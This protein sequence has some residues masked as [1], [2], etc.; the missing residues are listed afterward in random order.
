MEFID[1]STIRLDK[2]INELDR[3]VVKFTKILE[4]HTDYVIVSG[5]VSILFGRSRSTE[6]V[7]VFIK[8]VNKEKFNL[9]CSDLIENGFWCLNT[10]NVDEMYKYLMDDLAIRFALKNETIPNFEVK[11]AK[12]RLAKE[13]FSDRITVI[14]K[15]SEVYVSSLE[16][17]IAF[18][19]YYLKSDK[20]LEDA[21]HIEEVFGEKIDFKKID[22][23]K[24]LIENE[25]T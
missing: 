19:K 24:R 1:K 7:D 4:K 16:K 8:E 11:V 5:Y 22:D 6:D 18:K 9:L 14:T 20:D 25:K 12:D 10:S 15:L 23:Y 13:T 17:Q 21:K 3:F 2:V